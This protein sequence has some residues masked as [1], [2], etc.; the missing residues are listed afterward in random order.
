MV[1]FKKHL[2]T[3]LEQEDMNYHIENYL[4][5]ASIFGTEEEVEKAN[6]IARFEA[7]T[8][9]GQDWLYENINPYYRLLVKF[10]Q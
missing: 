6:Q 8:R 4:L 2:K 7:H 9:S 1:D 5:L 10:A 3:Y